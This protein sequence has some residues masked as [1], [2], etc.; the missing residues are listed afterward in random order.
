MPNGGRLTLT[1][2]N[3]TLGEAD[4]VLHAKAKPGNYVEVSVRDTGTGIPAEIVDRIFDPFFTTKDLEKGTGLGLSTVLGI[5]R[6][7]GGFVTVDSKVGVGSLFRVYLPAVCS[8]ATQIRSENATPMPVGEGE[9]VLVV[10]DEE[11]IRVATRQVLEGHNYRVIT[12][13]DGKEAVSRFLRDRERVRLVL[14]DVMMPKMGGGSLVRALRLIEPKLR[15]IAT[16]GLESAGAEL[17]ELGVKVL[18][19]PCSPSKLLE[20][21]RAA[22]TEA[23]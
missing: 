21:V 19:K 17:A 7:H 3:V 15:V 11:S 10:D 14:T 22:L 6:D 5:V 18:A 2:Q 1:V 9:V 12:A 23:R 8:A 16:S 4:R 13:S 20:E